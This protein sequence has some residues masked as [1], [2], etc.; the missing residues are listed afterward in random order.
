MCC[1]H[2]VAP[3]RCAAPC[4]VVSDATAPWLGQSLSCATPCRA[5]AGPGARYTE[6]HPGASVIHRPLH[7]AVNRLLVPA[8]TAPSAVHVRE[9]RACEAAPEG[10]PAELACP[11]TNALQTVCGRWLRRAS[12]DAARV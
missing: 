2:W 8:L 10:P 9:A 11:L 7:R 1:L 12:G 3:V 6:V 4:P 5:I